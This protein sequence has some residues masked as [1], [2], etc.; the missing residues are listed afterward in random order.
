MRHPPRSAHDVIIEMPPVPHRYV[1]LLSLPLPCF[2]HANSFSGLS[3]GNT[4]K[5]NIHYC[6]VRDLAFSFF[7]GC[8][9]FGLGDTLPFDPTKVCLY[10]VFPLRLGKRIRLVGWTAEGSAVWT[11]VFMYVR[12]SSYSAWEFWG[13]GGGGGNRGRIFSGIFWGSRDFG[14]G[15]WF[16]VLALGFFVLIPYASL[17]TC[18]VWILI[19]YSLLFFF[20]LL[21]IFIFFYQ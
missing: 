8:L 2:S 17:C 7:F 21:S 19:F 13:K 5:Q 9:C 10:G 16:W 3:I 20:L 12:K 18:E 14:F 1:L 4:C 15:F 6:R 11:Y